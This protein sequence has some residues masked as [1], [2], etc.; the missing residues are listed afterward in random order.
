LYSILI[1]FGVHMK[2]VRLTKMCLNETYSKVCIG[3]HLSDMFPIQNGLKQED[4]I[5]TTSFT[6]PNV[7]KL[8]LYVCIRLYMFRFLASHLQKA[9][10]HCKGNHHYMIYKYVK[11]VSTDFLYRSKYDI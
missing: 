4:A 6:P 5:K 1:E 2:L 3:K 8:Y 9:Y 10:Q 11:L 7:I